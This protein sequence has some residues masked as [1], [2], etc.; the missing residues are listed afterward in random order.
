MANDWA[1]ANKKKQSQIQKNIKELKSYTK[2]YD[3]NREKYLGNLYDTLG[4]GKDSEQF[5]Q[6]LN[7]QTGKFGVIHGVGEKTRVKK[8][9]AESDAN[10]KKISD[11][12]YKSWKVPDTPKVPVVKSKSNYIKDNIKAANEF[13][14]STKYTA[15]W[16][17]KTSLGDK[18]KQIKDITNEYVSKYGYLSKDA[19][20]DEKFNY[21]KKFLNVTNPEM[22]DEDIKKEYK[23]A[24]SYYGIPVLGDLTAFA[25]ENLL[26]DGGGISPVSMLARENEKNTGN[27][28]TKTAKSLAGNIVGMSMNPA[29][30]GVQGQNMLNVADDIS[31]MAANK[32]LGKYTNKAAGK[33]GETVLKN[34]IDGSV[35]GV[36]D[37][38]RDSDI[39]NLGKNIIQGALGDAVFGVATDGLGQ[40]IS[41]LK[42]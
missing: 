28:I 36:L 25:Q 21:Y 33:I 32:V 16:D 22:S 41:K 26:P 30:L 31:S 3:E 39:E 20:D 15:E 35:G 40:G 24:S 13:I 27:A 8:L 4:I 10:A 5:Q 1:S 6:H 29:N 19:S 9:K 14:P 18:N 2:K 11:E 37:T 7:I 12:K 42:G 23:K 17:G 38:L 34:A